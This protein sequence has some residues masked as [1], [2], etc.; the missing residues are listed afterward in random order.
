MSTKKVLVVEDEEDIS[1]LLA[2][3]LI[4]NEYSV[5]S[6]TSGEKA[7]DVIKN[8]NFDLV[9]LD[10]MLPGIN[11]IEVCKTLK[12]NPLTR[13]LPVIMLTAKGEEVDIIKGFECGADD[14][15]TKPFNLKVLMARV[16]T[17]LRRTENTAYNKDSVINIH[18]LRIDP[19][20]HEAILGNKPLK[21][22]SAEFKVL[23]LLASKPGWVLSRYTIID[24][25][26]GEDY[27]VTDRSVDVL[28]VGLRKKMQEYGSYI[29]TVRGVGYKFS[30]E[31]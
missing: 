6:V 26:R 8:D 11:G 16:K 15:V 23:H 3:N 12:S 21:L 18:N 7:L 13:E 29:E 30:L 10:L 28:M 22:T 2:I 20:K 25:I 31:G 1:K 5:T 17:A 14:Y 4:K 24:E 9:L 27:A 19:V